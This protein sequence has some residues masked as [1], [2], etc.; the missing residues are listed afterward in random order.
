MVTLI[1]RSVR[2][3]MAVGLALGF[4]AGRVSAQDEAPLP[5][6]PTPPP[7]VQER[8]KLARAPTPPGPQA[9]VDLL[10]QKIHLNRA[11]IEQRKAAKNELELPASADEPPDVKEQK[12]LEK[13]PKPAPRSPDLQELVE[14]IRMR[15]GGAEKLDKAKKAGARIPGPQGAPQLSPPRVPGPRMDAPVLGDASPEEQQNVLRVTKSASNVSVPGLGSMWGMD[16]MP[17]TSV[18][19][20]TFG[21]LDRIADPNNK[22]AGGPIDIKPYMQA[23]IYLINPGYY[24]I[25]FV[26]M[27]V[28]ATLRRY[29]PVTRTYS[30]VAKWD[31]SQGC[32]Y[33][34]YPYVAR[35]AAGYHYFYWL[36][37][38]PTVCDIYL[39]EVS[40][41]K[42]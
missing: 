36:P 31:N 21:P 2:C 23:G 24:L 25:N 7:E 26:A 41:T 40:V 4:Q 33:D 19:Q 30:D 39:T 1:G 12:R 6:S 16:Y 10:L 14:K 22:I 32:V 42:L 9:D 28:T 34:S 18:Y 37:E 3:G 5:A 38:A 35:L 17:W 29:D 8:E 20:G 27:Q 13:S 15:P 11:A